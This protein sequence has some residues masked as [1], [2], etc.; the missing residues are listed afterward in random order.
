MTY[1]RSTRRVVDT[2]EFSVAYNL[3]VRI[4]ESLGLAFKSNPTLF[5]HPRPQQQLAGLHISAARRLPD[6]TYDAVMALPRPFFVKLGIAS[7]FMGAGM[8]LF[9]IHTGFYDV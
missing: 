8:E 7:F 9:M 5:T 6:V 4:F 1:L 2:D 3:A